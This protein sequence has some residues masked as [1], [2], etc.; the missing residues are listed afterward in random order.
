VDIDFPQLGSVSDLLVIDPGLSGWYQSEEGGTAVA[1]IID[2]SGNMA[3]LVPIKLRAAGFDPAD[4][5]IGAFGSE[6]WERAMLPPLAL[7]RAN[8]FNGADFAPGTRR[9]DAA[10][11]VDVVP[12]VLAQLGR[13]PLAGARGRDLLSPAGGGEA[14]VALFC[15]THRPQAAR[16]LYGLR[17]DRRLIVLDAGARAWESF[18]LRRDPRERRGRRGDDAVAP[19][20]R[21]TLLATLEEMGVDPHAE[22]TATE[23]DEATRRALRSL[24]Y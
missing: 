21:A 1:G 8:A 20:W 13:P 10:S 4:F 14:D 18:D 11:L 2:L 12:T 16:T 3:G 5:P 6:G 24:G 19:E 9:R 23:L 22:E 17:S 15:E 7:A